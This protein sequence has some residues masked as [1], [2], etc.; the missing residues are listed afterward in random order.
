[1]A[2]SLLQQLYDGEVFPAE[3]IVPKNLEYSEL[4]RK[5]HGCPS[6]RPM[7]IQSCGNG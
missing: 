6:C 3:Q 4:C 2:K 5:L 1:M 7:I